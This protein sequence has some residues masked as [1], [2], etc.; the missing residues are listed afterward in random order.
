MVNPVIL[1]IGTD[2]LEQTVQ[3]VALPLVP[4][5]LDSSAVVNRA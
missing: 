5:F 1:S 4:Q 3:N 2:M